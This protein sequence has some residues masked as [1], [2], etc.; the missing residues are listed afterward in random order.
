MV[1][2]RRH[3]WQGII[4]KFSFPRFRAIRTIEEKS[5]ASRMAVDCPIP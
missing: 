1:N 4:N 5:R 3:R 2:T